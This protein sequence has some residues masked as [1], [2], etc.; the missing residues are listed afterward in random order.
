[1]KDVIY[2]TGHKNPDTDSICAAYSYTEFKNKT[3]NT[4]TVAVRL[5]NVSQETQYALD[6]FKVEAPKLINTVRLKVEDL[7]FD[8]IPPLA[9]NVSIRKAWNIMQENNIKTIPVVD[10]NNHLKGIVATSNIT[11]TYMDIWDNKILA[12]SKT[13]LTN[14]VETLEA[15]I[16]TINENVEFF[17]GKIVI[18]AM[19]P[20]SLESFIEEG[21]VA[22][23]GDRAD[24]MKALVNKN[25]SLII[26]ACS[27]TA[28]D[29]IVKLA[30]D[31]GVTIICTPYDSFT[32]SRLIVQSLPIDYIMTKK[33]IISL[34]TD[35]LVDEAK[36]VMSETR[37]SSYPVLTEDNTVA[38]MISRYHLIT[39]HKKK[40]IQVDHN[41]RGQSVDGLDEAEILEI[42]DHHRVA[43]IQT[44]GPIY[45]RNEPVGCCSTIVGKRF[46]ENDITPSREAAGLMCS[47]I[48][49]DSLLFK[50][51]TCT[52]EDVKMAKKLAAIAGIDI[53]VYGKELLKAGTSLSGKTVE[54]IFNQDFKPFVIQ[55]TKVG[56]AQVNTMDIEGFMGDLK[57]EM[58]VYMEAKAT[59]IGAKA[60]MLL[61]T[62]IIAE[63][64][65]VLV[66]GED[67][68]IAEEA[69]G[70]TLVDS[71]AFLPGV[72]SRKK[73]VVPPLTNAITAR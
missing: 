7:D 71:T 5:G 62:D 56:V 43:D 40:V 36:K 59:E 29:E 69:F 57:E 1:M 72:L 52:E 10:A 66:A 61:L 49:S 46:F 15:K 45:F 51:P 17:P 39:K 9:P 20:D 14:I 28:P 16:Q 37:H 33:D 58:L 30:K 42:L 21:D 68:A 55:G 18:A 48:I 54:Q 60:T 70:V 73:Q 32:A 31:N 41:E 50:S 11:A 65:Q 12:K 34:T 3:Q 8:T 26:V 19:Q 47:A 6:Y 13:P 67:P 44:S 4:P 63:G 27:H 35:E 64:S 2:V 22:I 53:D 24:A 25:V 38:G 23:V